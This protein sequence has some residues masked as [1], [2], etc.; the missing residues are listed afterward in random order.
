MTGFFETLVS[1]AWH[2]HVGGVTG[3]RW[4]EAGRW[5]EAARYGLTDAV[6]AR[7]APPVLDLAL[8]VLERDGLPGALHDEVVDTVE[9]RFRQAW[10]HLR[11]A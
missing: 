4:T 8:R 1:S 5:V 9:Q 7:T 10:P 11:R 3:D 6:V 2:L